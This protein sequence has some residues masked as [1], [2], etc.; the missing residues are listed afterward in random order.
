MSAK[1]NG[2]IIFNK[3]LITK[4]SKNVVKINPRILVNKKNHPFF[5][6]LRNPRNQRNFLYPVLFLLFFILLTFLG[7]EKKVK[8][9]AH[10]VFLTF[11][12]FLLSIFFY[13]TSLILNDNC[14]IYFILVLTFKFAIPGTIT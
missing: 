11:I 1:I 13:R 14:R 7:C 8:I 2:I 6:K 9:S 4:S 3:Y 5:Y 10:S 12:H